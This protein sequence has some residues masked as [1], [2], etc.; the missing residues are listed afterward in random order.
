MNNWRGCKN[1]FWRSNG[2]MGDPD[3]IIEYDGNEYV[4]NYYDIEDAL[5]YDFCD[6]MEYVP[7]EAE[8]DP[9]IENQFDKYCQDYAYSYLEDCIYGGYFEEGSYSWHDRY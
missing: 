1:V 5:W 3:I 9:D 8:N 4:F 6:A 7:A 2:S